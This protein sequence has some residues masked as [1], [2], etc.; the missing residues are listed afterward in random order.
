MRRAKVLKG[1]LSQEIF[2]EFKKKSEL[3]VDCEMMGLNPNRDRLC[4]VQIGGE[5]TPIALVQV[6]EKTGAPLLKEVLESASITK[7]FHF[8]RLDCLFLKV[9]LGIEVQNL[10]CTKIASKLVR[11]YTDR[12]GLKEV[13]REF[14][15]EDLNKSITSSDW[16][17]ATLSAEQINYAEDDVKYLFKIK[18]T[19]ND[20]AER[21]GR[22][23]LMKATFDY[24]PH[25]VELDRLGY[26]EL[27]DH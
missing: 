19:L 26:T 13:V 9:R 5:D 24:L 12:H 25:R 6:D 21:E 1:D 11:T 22:A 15:G 18:R 23:A 10:F 16:G 3:G 2:E 20:M 4:L 17:K 7:I 8:A 14:A 27:Y